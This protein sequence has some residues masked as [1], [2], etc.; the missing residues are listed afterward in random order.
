MASPHDFGNILS[1]IPRT[2]TVV[3]R[4]PTGGTLV[5]RDLA[6]AMAT[7]HRGRAGTYGRTLVPAGGATRVD[8][9]GTPM[10]ALYG[11]YHSSLGYLNRGLGTFPYAGDELHVGLRGMRAGSTFIGGLG[12]TR[13]E[14]EARAA[15]MLGKPKAA[16]EYYGDI[17]AVWAGGSVTRRVCEIAQSGAKGACK[18]FGFAWGKMGTAAPTPTDDGEARLLKAATAAINDFVAKMS[19]GQLDPSTPAPEGSMN[20]APPTNTANQKLYDDYQFAKGQVPDAVTLGTALWRLQHP[21][22]TGGSN[23]GS[24]GSGSAGAG[25][26]GAGT[27]TPAGTTTTGG[28]GGGGVTSG[29]PAS[30]GADIYGDGN[31]DGSGGALVVGDRAGTSIVPVGP[32]AN[33]KPA[34]SAAVPAKRASRGGAALGVGALVLAGIAAYAYSKRKHG[35]RATH[36]EPVK[37]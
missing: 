29:T 23:G 25:S 27:Q 32:T 19:A 24:P 4:Q 21:T 14:M 17:G 20:L 7:N 2:R 36:H 33:S 30:S 5:S 8:R 6:V 37:L 22:P 9:D 18:K 16:G 15:S 1:A 12:E 34:A 11:R 10:A 13:D 3:H 28:G 26:G 31:A 35:G